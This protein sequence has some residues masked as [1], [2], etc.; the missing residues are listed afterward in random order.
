M[1][2]QLKDTFIILTLSIL[3]LLSFELFNKKHSDIK[4]AGEPFT[5]SLSDRQAWEYNRL[6]DPETGKIPYKIRQ[7]ELEF[8]KTLPND[9]NFSYK[10]T[11]WEAWGPYNVGGRT[12]AAAIDVL[13]ENI[14]IAGGV[15]GGVWRSVNGGASW[16]KTTASD[17]LHNITCIKQDTRPWKTNTW[18][19]GT[20]E[21]YGNSAG[22][23]NAY[24][25]GDGLFKSTD[26]GQTWQQVSSTADGNP[27]SFTTNWQI[28]WNIALDPSNDTAD[29]IYAAI[30][31]TIM[32]SDDGG[33]TWS[34]PI[35]AS[36]SYFT[37]VVTTTD[38]VVYATLS[39]DGTKGGIWRSPDGINWTNITPANFSNQFDRIVMAV[40]PLNQNS[41]YFLGV[42][43]DGSG[44]QTLTWQGD[45]VS[46]C[47]WKY[48]YHCGDG[49][50]SCGTWIDLSQN[51]PNTGN[52]SFDNFYAQGSYDLA[53]SVKPN[54]SNCVFIGGTNLYRSTD[55]FTTPNNTVQIGGYEIG[56]SL[57]DF[58]VY[59]GHHPDIHD[60][61]FL[62]SNPDVL[63]TASDGGVHKTMNCL[64]NPVSWESLNNGY[65]T[66]QLYTINFNYEDTSDL[67]IAGFQDNGNYYINSSNPSDNWVMTLNGD[68]SYSAICNNASIFYQSIQKGKIYKMNID[69]NGIPLAYRRIDPIGKHNYL[70]IAPFVV[71][72]NNENIMYLAAG[73][74]LYR[75]D[76]LS[77]INLTNQHDSI[78]QGWFKL[79]D[80]VNYSNAVISSFGISASNPDI[81]YIGSSSR[82]VYKINNAS[83]GDPAFEDISTVAFQMSVYFNCIAVDPNDANI[84]LAVISNYNTYSLFYT[85]DGGQNWSKVG[86]NLEQNL[87]GYG[88]GPSL[89]WADFLHIGND[90]LY[91]VASSTGLYA[92]HQ[93]RG[94]NTVW[95]QI[96]TNTIGNVVCEMVK[97]RQQDGLVVVATHGNG[98]YRTKV[99]SVTDILNIE[100]PGQNNN[101]SFYPNPATNCITIK[102]ATNSNITIY[103]SEGKKFYN[104]MCD[105]EYYLINTESFSPGVYYLRISNEKVNITKPII[106][107]K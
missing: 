89:R 94:H 8:A 37:D 20:G 44:Q 59:P 39:S 5:V 24:F 93:L 107:I 76:S 29:V 42:T 14:I 35:G 3:L 65:Y 102:N 99:K 30:Y 84:A 96:G 90:T 69:N 4:L 63:F 41:V 105:N 88:N 6:K 48:T 32:R 16:I 23:T 83:T 92:T 103:N 77:Y 80:S 34:N 33:N 106:I 54:D 11:Q 81:L 57:P 97:C 71:D 51:L 67:M 47:L 100:K 9:L 58:H 73:K 82:K 74:Y 27:Q 86:G 79:S 2:N 56:T 15:S 13:N 85:K 91:F 26:N 31:G 43:L 46:H 52:I 36:Y 45:T 66:T 78:S 60:I 64:D 55:A 68:G 21:G 72:P 19:Y 75:N 95:T 10:S 104:K 38:G 40:N 22:A 7:K 17:Q 28:V 101:I 53:I 70:F 18:Y 62:P 25:L 49:S 61:F 1:P 50:D 98:I 12:R 87:S